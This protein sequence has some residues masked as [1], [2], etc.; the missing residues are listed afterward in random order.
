[1]QVNLHPSSGN[2]FNS[3]SSN[4]VII[5]HIEYR[6]NLLVSPQQII[7]LDLKNITALGLDYLE[8]ILKLDPDI[9]IFGSGT[10]IIYP[11]HDIVLRLQQLQIGYEVMSIP[12]L[13]RTFNYLI[14]EGRRV[15]GIIF[16]T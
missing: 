5:N 8:T 14:G 6:G 4:S 12:A 13:C 3:Y 7:Q 16:F 1:M 9:I 11:N 10:T 15:T 2:Q